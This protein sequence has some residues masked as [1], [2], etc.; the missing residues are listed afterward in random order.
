MNRT[1]KF[2]LFAAAIFSLTAC[3]DN[4]TPPPELE[5][6]QPGETPVLD[7]VPELNGRIDADQLQASIGTPV[8]YRISPAGEERAVD[9]RGQMD[10]D[11]V[12]IWDWSTAHATDQR[13][14]IEASEITG[15]WYASEFP[16]GEFSTLL[17]PDLGWDGIYSHDQEGLH[18]HGYASITENPSAGK[19]LVKYDEPVTLYR[20]PLEVG[21]EWSS[22]GV[23]RNATIQGIPYAGEDTYETNVD[24]GGELWLPDLL[25]TDVLRVN[26]QVT[27]DPSIGAAS[28]HRQVSFF[29]ECFGEVARVMSQQ[30]EE[31]EE[32][33]T[34]VEMRRLGF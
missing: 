33:T 8:G 16:G 30:G 17:N 28:T 29:F 5:A 32:F 14:E 13:L 18:F 31:E 6:Y 11:G 2:S 7:C 10:G 20:F 12:R 1:P 15:K 27:I 34:A 26:T 25:F 21:R 24:A 9:L 3:V 23:V 4:Q 22:H 19:T